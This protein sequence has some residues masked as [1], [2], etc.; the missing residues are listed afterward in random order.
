MKEVYVAKGVDGE[1]LYVGQGNLGRNTHC[2]GGVSHNKHLNRYFFSN[3]EKGSITTEILYTV[4]TQEEALDLEKKMILELDPTFN[5]YRYGQD[6]IMQK[7]STNF[8]KYAKLVY[9]TKAQDQEVLDSVY[10]IHPQ[11]KEYL[12]VLG[13][14]ILKT[15]GYQESKIKLKFNESIGVNGA[16]KRLKEVQS[17]LDFKVNGKYTSKELKD[18]FAECFKSLGI[19]KTA[20]ASCVFDYYNVTRAN[21]KGCRGYSILGVVKQ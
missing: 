11:I 16:S 20:K 17:Y 3:G 18:V 14:E 9:D 12:N 7:P 15:L 10:Q 8:K 21:I 2:L 5:M 13:F 6:V 1:V 19:N 4:K